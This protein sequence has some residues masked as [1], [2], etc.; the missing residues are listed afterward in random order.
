MAKEIRKIDS[1][2]QII[3]TS[4]FSEVKY[5]QEAIEIGVDNYLLKPINIEKLLNVIHKRD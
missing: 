2:V 3:I 1:T 4:A 5:F